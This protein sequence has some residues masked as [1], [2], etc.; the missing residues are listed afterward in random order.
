MATLLGTVLGNPLRNQRISDRRRHR[1]PL[2]RSHPHSTNPTRV[3]RKLRER[4]WNPHNDQ[5]GDDLH[6]RPGVLD[7]DSC[8][9]ASRQPIHTANPRN[10]PPKPRH[11]THARRLHRH[12]PLR[13]HSATRRPQH[14]RVHPPTSHRLRLRPRSNLHRI[15]PGIHPTHHKI[16]LCHPSNS[17]YFPH[18]LQDARPHEPPIRRN[19]HHP[20]T[21]RVDQTRGRP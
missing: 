20:P 16:R 15:L 17:R 7:H 1:A 19:R 13:P 3:C 11:P 18:H 5:H 2:P 10:I 14:E 6:N 8:P 9:P 21:Q 4:P 12:F